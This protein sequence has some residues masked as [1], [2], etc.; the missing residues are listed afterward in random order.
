[1]NNLPTRYYASEGN[2]ITPAVETQSEDRGQI[3]FL[4]RWT[5]AL[6]RVCARLFFGR[7]T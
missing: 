2:E 5:L 4:T 3:T 6:Y 1:M 7:N